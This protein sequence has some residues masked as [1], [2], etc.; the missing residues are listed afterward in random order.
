MTLVDLIC[1]ESGIILGRVEDQAV[2]DCSH[3]GPCDADV[4]YWQPQVT[5]LAEAAALRRYVASYG[6]EVEGRSEETIRELAL[7]LAC[8]DLRETAEYQD[9]AE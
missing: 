4:A 9:Q 1:G 8:G 6:C 2:H 7:W 5:W 3:Q